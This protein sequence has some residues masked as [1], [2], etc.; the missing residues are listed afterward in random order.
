[1]KPFK[2][3]ENTSECDWYVRL[4]YDFLDHQNTLSLSG[5]AFKIYI[6]MRILAA[7]DRTTPEDVVV[8]TV[9]KAAEYARVSEPSANKALLELEQKGYTKRLNN[10]KEKRVATEWK[11]VPD[12]QNIEPVAKNEDGYIYVIK[13]GHEY[14]I[15]RTRNPAKRMCT[16]QKTL[17]SVEQVVCKKVKQHC[18][19]EKA[20]HKTYEN[21]RIVG[22]WFNLTKNDLTEI[23]NY[24]SKNEVKEDE[25]DEYEC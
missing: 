17:G 12:W 15:G 7:R 14:K 22:E 1:M 2:S 9:R 5:C 20:L 24:L 3:W 4:P 16:F 18:F 25:N 23:D 21:K 13:L 11:F 8:L 6:I 10:S 19:A